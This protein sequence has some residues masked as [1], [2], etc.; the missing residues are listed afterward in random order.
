VAAMMYFQPIAGAALAWVWLNE[1]QPPAFFI[2]SALTFIGV[3]L[4][5]GQSARP[6]THPADT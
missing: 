5:I 6:A 2:G 1:Q 3:W 4:V